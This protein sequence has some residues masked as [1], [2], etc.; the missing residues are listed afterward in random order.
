MHDELRPNAEYVCA[1]LG[2]LD[3]TGQSCAECIPA[4]A[5]SLDQ[6]GMLALMDQ[7]DDEGNRL[8]DF[9]IA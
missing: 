1:M 4:S 8:L 9:S 5:R 7:E 3:A 2:M 6:I